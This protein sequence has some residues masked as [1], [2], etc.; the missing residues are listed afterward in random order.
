MTYL[1]LCGKPQQVRKL[2]MDILKSITNA[3]YGNHLGNCMIEQNITRIKTSTICNYDFQLLL[4]SLVRRDY[5]TS[6]Q[7][8]CPK[9]RI[10]GIGLIENIYQ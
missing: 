2:H 9:S 3:A 5:E 7:L 6:P 1:Y 8:E 4:P 10:V